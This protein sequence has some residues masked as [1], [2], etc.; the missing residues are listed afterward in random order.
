M[1]VSELLKTLE[2]HE[3]ALRCIFN[4]RRH[5]LD[6][7][8]YGMGYDFLTILSRI[9]TSK[10]QKEMYSFMCDALVDK[11]YFERPI[12]ENLLW[13]IILPEWLI[14]ICMKKFS[15]SREEI[16]DQVKKDDEDS[17]NANQINNSFNLSLNL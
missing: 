17:F 13:T 10:Q 8:N 9:A 6:R 4:E 2:E 16:I 1:E 7:F 15:R 11:K 12:Y 3:A 14:A 5:K